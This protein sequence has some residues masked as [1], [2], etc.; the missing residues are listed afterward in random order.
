MKAQ[1]NVMNV[2]LVDLKAQYAA[3]SGEVEAAISEVLQATNFILGA[4]VDHF[5]N[6]FAAYCETQHAIGVDSGLSGLELALRMYGVGPGDEVITAANTFIATALAISH[7]GARP[8]LVDMDPDTY[9][10]DP[11]ALEKAITK[12][13]KAIMPVHLYGQTVDM[14]PIMEIASRY[15]LPVIEDACQSHGARYK[16]RRAGSL[17]HMAAFSFYPG[18]NLG[19]YGDGGM[20]VTNDGEMADKLRVLRNYGQ[21]EKYHHVEQG[22]NRRLDTIQA[23]VLRVKLPYLDSWNAARRECARMYNEILA[24]TGAVLPVVAPYA[25]MVWHLY[26]IRVKNRDALKTYLSER[27]IGAGIHY[28]IPI[29]L[30]PAYHSLGYKQGDFPITERFADEILSLPIYPELSPSAI[31]HVAETIRDFAAQQDIQ[32]PAD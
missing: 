20:I 30:Q 12:Q 5:E 29:H 28:P 4:Q 11:R 17:G 16:G 21:R 15:E 8:V 32:P 31:E 1:V 14:D 2:P 23:A 10:L 13:T 25:E 22:Y 6:E 27:G 26:V 9:E 3:I 18:K 7:A 19:A 24:D